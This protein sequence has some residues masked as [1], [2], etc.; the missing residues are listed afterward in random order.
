MTALVPMALSAKQIALFKKTYTSGEVISEPLQNGLV[1]AGGK[2]KDIWASGL[3]GLYVD[4]LNP[5]H[6]H[7]EG[8]RRYANQIVSNGETFGLLTHQALSPRERQRIGATTMRLEVIE[9]SPL[10]FLKVERAPTQDQVARL[11]LDLINRQVSAF[12]QLMASLPKEEDEKRQFYQSMSEPFRLSAAQ[13]R[14]RR[15]ILSGQDAHAAMDELSPLPWR[16]RLR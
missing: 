5:V 4:P 10:P 15:A 11:A 3:M 6:F 2:L 12:N 13:A 14:L 16:R 1:F 7:F 9:A 8:N